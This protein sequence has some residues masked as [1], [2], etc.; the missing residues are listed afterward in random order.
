[1]SSIVVFWIGFPLIKSFIKSVQTINPNMF[2]LLG[3]GTLTAYFYSLF[4]LINNGKTHA[5]L[6]FDAS[7]AI[8]T[9]IVAI[10]WPRFLRSPDHVHYART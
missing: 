5:P 3:S 6:F 4:V 1:M 7:A 9:L 8:T 10:M 2:T